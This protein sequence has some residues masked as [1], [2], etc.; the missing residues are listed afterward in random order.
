MGFKDNTTEYG[1]GQLG[2]MFSDHNNLSIKP[3]IGKVFV[4]IT[5]IEDTKFDSTDGVVADN[6]S[7]HGLEYV[8]SAFARD[9]DGTVNDGAHDEGVPTALLGKGGATIDVSDIFPRGLTI[10]G[11]W[12]EIDLTDGKIIAYIGD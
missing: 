3:P 10:Y 9:A 7:E 5:M 12:T 11:R 6:N 8:G 2:S 4:A 1:F